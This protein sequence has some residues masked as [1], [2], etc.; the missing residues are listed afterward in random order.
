[1]GGALVPP[2]DARAAA[3]AALEFLRDP[4]RARVDGREG[5]ALIE[6]RLNW[7]ALVPRLTGLYEELLG[8]R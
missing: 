5:R 4:D 2:G 1:V 3:E 7:D 6:E 8:G